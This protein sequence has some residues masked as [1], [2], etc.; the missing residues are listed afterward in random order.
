MIDFVRVIVL[1]N[2][3]C[4]KNKGLTCGD[5]FF[6]D[7]FFW[8]TLFQGFNGGWWGLWLFNGGL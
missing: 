6:K 8:A 5:R 2:S 3:C 4:V 7:H 1:Q